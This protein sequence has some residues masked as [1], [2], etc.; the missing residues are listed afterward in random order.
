LTPSEVGILLVASI[1]ISALSW[2]FVETP[3]RSK[4]FISTRQIFAFG[5]SGMALMLFAGGVVY[6][7][8]GFPERQGLEY[9]VK[10]E[11]KED[12]WLFK[13]CNINYG[14]NPETI[15]P[16]E[17]GDKSQTPSFMIIGDSH[18]PTYGKAVHR[19]AAQSGVSGI[20]T[21]AQGCP[22]LLDIIPAPKVGDVP[23][24]TYN[25]MALSYLKEH[26]EI[27][28]VIL[29][30]RWT[31]WLE[32]SRYKQEE[33]AKLQLA[34]ALNEAPPNA[35]KEYLFTL[36][37]ERTIKALLE[38][39][40]HVVVIA[41]LPEIG[42]DVPSANFI[43]SRTGR[44]INELIAPSLEEYFARSQKTF[45]ILQSFEGKYGIPIIEPWK[46]L[47][48]NDKCRAAI[49]GIPLYN[50]DDHLSVF[51]SELV[52]PIFDP[53]FETIRQANK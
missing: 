14:D 34:D 18:T 27:H 36:G 7:F 39:D 47:C 48:A 5:A 50:D 33:G 3:F 38:L 28:T 22:T 19:S 26:P 52:T 49:N 6:H 20:L 12:I 41:P 43:A 15:T 10:D 31:A 4:N 45:T 1:L 40:R 44:D 51:G 30:S 8:K 29:A 13:E 53:L 32:E 42:Y 37:L 16:C 2:R 11:K 25:H 9:L 35:S 24:V 46:V 17:V 23:C 21:Y